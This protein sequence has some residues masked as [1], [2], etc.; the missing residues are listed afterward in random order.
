MSF[1]KFFSSK[2]PTSSRVARERLQMVIAHQRSAHGSPDFLPKLQ[3]DILTVIAKYVQVDMDNIKVSL[4]R[5]SGDTSILEVNVELP[6][7]GCAANH[8][9]SPGTR[10]PATATNNTHRS[11]RR[12][13]RYRR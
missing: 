7:P 1:F 5:S 10:A 6:D 8:R 13:K 2:K 4:D 3:A 12:R 11:R 9:E